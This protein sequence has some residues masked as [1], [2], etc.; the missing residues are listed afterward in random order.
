MSSVW[1]VVLY[2]CTCTVVAEAAVRWAVV[3]AA[4][5]RWVDGKDESE[6][7]GLDLS[8]KTPYG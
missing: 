3:D 1:C 8:D 4:S 5:D 6:M 2:T 7:R